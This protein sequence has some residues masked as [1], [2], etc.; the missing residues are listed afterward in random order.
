MATQNT[1]RGFTVEQ[2]RR[3]AWKQYYAEKE[4]NK[5]LCAV[6]TAMTKS[7]IHAYHTA[8]SAER[9][10]LTDLI[11]KAIN[12]QPGEFYYKCYTKVLC[13]SK[14]HKGVAKRQ[15]K[16]GEEEYDAHFTAEGGA[17][18][19]WKEG[20]EPEFY[21]KAYIPNKADGFWRLTREGVPVPTNAILKAMGP[22]HRKSALA[23]ATGIAHKY[24]TMLDELEYS[25]DADANLIVHTAP[26]VEAPAESPK[27]KV[28]KI[29]PRGTK[30]AEKAAASGVNAKGE[31][32]LDDEMFESE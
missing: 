11:W 26:K 10:P 21:M 7:L 12:E 25:I 3:F 17:Y 1:P 31:E 32:V 14:T 8:T 16:D 4:E 29:K 13:G 20:D 24:G 23:R 27:G 19:P 2:E 30:A 22:A 9:G 5:E 18:K 15:T 6:I 28:F